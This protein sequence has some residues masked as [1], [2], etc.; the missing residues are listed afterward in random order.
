MAQAG[1]PAA[2]IRAHHIATLPAQKKALAKLVFVGL[3]QRLLSSI[4]AFVRTLK[5]H[6]K[7]LQRVVDGED[8]QGVSAAAEGFVDGSTT[9]KT[10]DLDLEDQS[11]ETAIDADEE[12]TAEAAS[13]IGLIDASPSDLRQELATVDEMLAFAEHAALK[14]DARVHWLVQWIKTIFLSGS[15]W[16][17]RRLIIFTE[18]ED[19]RRWLER[20]LR[21]ALAETDKVD[22]RIAVFT[23][24]TGQDR[25][26]EVKAAFNADP[27]KEPLRILICTDAARE[28]INLQT[29]CADLIHFDLPWNPSRLEQRNGRIDRKL[30]PAKQVFCRYF[31]YEQREADIVLEALVRKTE[32][33]QRQ[34]IEGHAAH[35]LPPVPPRGRR[36]RRAMIL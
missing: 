16:N 36:Y 24:T 27:A 18:W 7:T 17:N 22:D 34:L 9:D 31:R 1:S 30:Q 35:P 21:E 19:T 32:V 15:T 25:R 14:P 23:G 33:I 26:E 4:A 6:R 5:A 28:G 20:R 8:A 10:E 13:V 11:A 12:A 2:R 3:Q 29:Y